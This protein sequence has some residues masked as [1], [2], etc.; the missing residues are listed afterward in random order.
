MEWSV[1]KGV[2]ICVELNP[3]LDVD[4]RKQQV[5]IDDRLRHIIVGPLFEILLTIPGHG[6]SR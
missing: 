3:S 2:V 1:S 5:L 6:M 4:R